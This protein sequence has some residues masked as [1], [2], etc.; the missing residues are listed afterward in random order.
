MIETLETPRLILRPFT[1]EDLDAYYRLGATPALVRYVGGKMLESLDAARQLML[2][3][4]LRDYEVHGYGRLAVIEKATGELIGF[5]GLKNDRAIGEIDIGYRF[6]ESHWG[7]GFATESAKAAMTYGR[8]VLGLQRIV[9]IVQPANTASV[10]VL[11]KLGLVYEKRIR[12]DGDG[13]EC[14]LY[15]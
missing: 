2:S 11:K 8:E 5:S 14:D 7:K 15:A 1:L 12:Y 4:T 6:F 9:G 3:A 13:D 10:H